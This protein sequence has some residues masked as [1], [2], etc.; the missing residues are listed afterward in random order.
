MSTYCQKLN[1]CF[2]MK[3]FHLAGIY[4]AQTNSTDEVNENFHIWISIEEGKTIIRLTTHQ[5]T[6]VS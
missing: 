3:I 1:L 6:W 5:P 4:V 2:D